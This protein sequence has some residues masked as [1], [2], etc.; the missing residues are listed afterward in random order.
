MV[1]PRIS[2]AGVADGRARPCCARLLPCRTRVISLQLH[3]ASFFS[4]AL[5]HR[6]IQTMHTMWAIIALGALALV[7][8]AWATQSLLAAPQGNDKMKEIA[9]A[10]QEGAQA[11]L[12]RQYTTIAVAGAAI[13]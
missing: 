9:A 6:D 12:T 10:I 11:Y 1:R 2:W 3:R 5:H 4:R 13:F 8:G 7:Y